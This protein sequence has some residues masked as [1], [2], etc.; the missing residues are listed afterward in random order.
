MTNITV[1]PNVVSGT[2]IPI[3]YTVTNQGARDPHR[4]GRTASSSRRTP[5]STPRHRVGH[6]RLRPGLA[7]GAFT[8]RRL[9]SACPTASR[10]L[11]HPGVRRLGCD[12]ELPVAERHPATASTASRLGP[13][14]SWT[15]T[16][17]SLGDPQPGPRPRTPVRERSR[18][19]GPRSRCP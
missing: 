17:W 9:T 6:L 2:T 5:R 13:P 3:T 7:A 12:H 11:R 15:P 8:P 10:G 18:Q 4:A 16:T 19:A 14:T 1:P